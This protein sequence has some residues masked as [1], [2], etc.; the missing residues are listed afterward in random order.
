MVILSILDQTNY[1]TVNDIMTYDCI[2]IKYISIA[3][4]KKFKR[5]SLINYGSKLI[6]IQQVKPKQKEL[7][8]I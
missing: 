4:S 2:I 1:F 3:N 6:D 7:L 5:V 8:T